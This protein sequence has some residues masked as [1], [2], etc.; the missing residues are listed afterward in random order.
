MVVRRKTLQGLLA[1]ALLAIVPVAP[2]LAA[3][4]FPTQPITFVVPFGAGSGTDIAARHYGK[5]L[6][7][8]TGQPVIVENRP[9][10]NGFVAVRQVLAAPADGHTVFIGSNSTLAVNAAIFKELPYDPVADFSPLSLLMRSP[11]LIMV[12]GTSSHNTLDEFITAAKENPGELNYGAG[13]AG[14]QLMAEFFNETAGVQ[15]FHVPFNGGNETMAAVASDVVQLTFTEIIS[16]QALVK[17]GKVRALAVASEQRR[18]V[19]P[20]VPTA[21]EAGLP[22]FTAFTWVAAMT[23]VATPDAVTEKLATWFTQIADMPETI[24]FYESQGA[25]VGTTGPEALQQFQ[26]QDIELWK[27]IVKQANIEL[28]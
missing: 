4:N 12:P 20:D 17:S 3:D 22:G 25:E 23:P 14:Y 27:R 9:G 16:A 19:L 8:L 18:P 11:A 26:E 2:T 28:R 10:A 15:T 13:S 24:E 21:D 5:Y 1:A 7:D 6:Q